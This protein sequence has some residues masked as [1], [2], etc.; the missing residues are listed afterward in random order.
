MNHLTYWCTNTVTHSRLGRRAYHTSD[1]SSN[2]LLLA[3]PT[4]GQTFHNN[5]HAFP[6]S[7]IMG[8]EWWRIDTGTWILRGLE[9]V[10]LVW[11][12]KVPDAKMMEKKRVGPKGGHALP[13]TVDEAK[14]HELPSKPLRGIA[15]G[16]SVPLRRRE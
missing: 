15:R 12:I 5:H 14:R 6:S 13:S 4:L 2:S 9:A 3:I 16:H 10:G 8:H 1:R 11:D 7:A